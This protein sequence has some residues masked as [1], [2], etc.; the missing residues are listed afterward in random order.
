MSDRLNK[1]EL[2]VTQQYKTL[3]QIDKICTSMVQTMGDLKSMCEKL[4]VVINFH[5]DSLKDIKKSSAI[6]K[7]RNTEKF[8]VLLK[9]IHDSRID[10]VTNLSNIRED[11]DLKLS[12]ARSDISAKISILEKWQWK[13]S[14][15]IIGLVSLITLLPK[16]VSFFS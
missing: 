15:L 8:D 14:G 9:E 1:V 4:D 5:D 2:E 10:N 16:I 3:N 7:E 6:Q 12:S 11:F 13:A